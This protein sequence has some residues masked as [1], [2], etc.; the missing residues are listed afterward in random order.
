MNDSF[1]LLLLRFGFRREHRFESCS[2]AYIFAA[3]VT[4]VV[5]LWHLG[6]AERAHLHH[7]YSFRQAGSRV[8]LLLCWHH[9]SWSISVK[10]CLFLLPCILLLYCCLPQTSSAASADPVPAPDT[11]TP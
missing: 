11:L 9:P 8:G 6:V 1:L 2:I 5:A 3:L 7:G 4:V 10:R